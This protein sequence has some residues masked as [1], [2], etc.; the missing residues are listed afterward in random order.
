[1][2]ASR[3]GIEERDGRGVRDGLLWFEEAVMPQGP[4]GW[5]KPPV[6]A[7]EVAR[8]PRLGLHQ[9]M[10]EVLECAPVAG[11]DHLHDGPA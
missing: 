9:G 4:E 6:I 7:P 8:D 1:L 3:D 10:D 5:G 11:Q 2:L